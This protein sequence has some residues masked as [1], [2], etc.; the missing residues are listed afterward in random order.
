[1][2]RSRSSDTDRAPGT[3][4][5]RRSTSGMARSCVG[6]LPWRPLE[7]SG[8]SVRTSEVNASASRL[9]PPLI[10]SASKRFGVTRETGGTRL[11]AKRTSSPPEMG[12]DM[13]RRATPWH[14]HGGARAEAG[15]ARAPPRFAPV[16]PCS[17]RKQRSHAPWHL[18]CTATQQRPPRLREPGLSPAAEQLVLGGKSKFTTVS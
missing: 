3:G 12:F 8:C 10:Q 9:T 4:N 1:V 17:S 11:A 18:F 5:A 13:S 14:K 16:R 7:R 2:A 15:F 6:P